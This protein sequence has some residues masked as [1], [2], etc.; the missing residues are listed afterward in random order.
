LKDII[1]RDVLV[2][3][4]PTNMYTAPADGHFSEECGC[5]IKPA[6]MQAKR[7]Y[8]GARGVVDTVV[9]R[10]LSAMMD[11][12]VGRKFF[13]NVFRRCISKHLSPFEYMRAAKMTCRDF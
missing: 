6:I 1:W 8:R 13:K 2:L 7:K 3:K 12:D 5:T 9:K 11:K 4:I 10:L